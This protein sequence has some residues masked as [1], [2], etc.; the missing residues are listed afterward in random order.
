MKFTILFTQ[1]CTLAC[2]YCYI[3]KRDVSISRETMVKIIDFIYLKTPEGQ[4]IDVG[5]FGG[6]PLL[7]FEK[8]KIFTSLLKNHPKS[9][10]HPLEIQIVTN[11]TIFSQEIVTYVNEMNMSLVISCDGPPYVQDINRRYKNGTSSSTTVE[12]SIREAVAGVNVFMVNSVY[13]PPT[14]PYLLDT[15][16]Y[17]Y[18][19]G[20]RY[21]FLNP[22]LSAKWTKEDV[23]AIHSIFVKIGER[24]LEW[25]DGGDPAMISIIDNKLS[26][27]LNQGCRDSDK[28]HMG[29]REFAFTPDGNIFPCERLV[30]SG[31][32]NEHCIGNIDTGV[33]LTK[34]KASGF[35]SGKEIAD[36]LI[37]SMKK[38]CMNWCGC[39]NFFS[40]GYYDK[41]GPFICAYE[42]ESIILASSLFQELSTRFGATLI[43]KLID[44]QYYYCK[45]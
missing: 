39:S 25:Y 29:T 10:H 30:Y 1:N 9:G 8:I 6:E 40:T 5:Y 22:D 41:V 7:E 45:V 16:N 27:L 33:D 3:W 43:P 14:L 35:F 21:I 34:F 32:M 20:V 17:F 36:C 15:I 37:C 42:K 19:L 4:K 11:G 24:Y 44:K 2:P 12:Q 13:T 38:Y 31:E 18:D 28:C 23:D 26:L